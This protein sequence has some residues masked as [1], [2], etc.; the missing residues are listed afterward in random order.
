[1][2]A[3]MQVEILPLVPYHDTLRYVLIALALA[4]LA[5]VICARLDDWQKGHR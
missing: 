3:D 4:G 2:L 1:M 5:V